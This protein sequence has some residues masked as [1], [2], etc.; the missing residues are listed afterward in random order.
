MFLFEFTPWLLFFLFCQFIMRWYWFYVLLISIVPFKTIASL[1]FWFPSMCHHY[2]QEGKV[3]GRWQ[4][5]NVDDTTNFE[6]KNK[7]TMSFFDWLANLFIKVQHLIL[8]KWSPILT[9]TPSLFLLY[10]THPQ[11]HDHYPLHIMQQH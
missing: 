3:E 1:S 9:C 2:R 7:S 6:W 8:N 10:V 5:K 11:F 4:Y